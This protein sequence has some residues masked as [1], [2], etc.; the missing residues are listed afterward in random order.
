M[1]AGGDGGLKSSIQ[2]FQVCTSALDSFKNSICNITT[3][4]IP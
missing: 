1:V 4:Y 3:W 2:Y